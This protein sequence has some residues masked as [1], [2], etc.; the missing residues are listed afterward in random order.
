MSLC[1]DCVIVV[2]HEGTPKGKI[3]KIGG[4]TCYVGT[5]TEECTRDGV[6]LCLTD[7]FGID[8]INTQLL[9]DDF[10]RCGFKTIAIDYLHGDPIPADA[11]KSPGFHDMIKTWIANHGAER[12]RAPIDRVVA[13][14]KDQRVTRFAAVGYCLGGRYA[15]DLAF[16]GVIEVTVVSH[17]SF[18]NIPS[19]LQK[20]KEKSKAPLLIN[21]CE[22]DDQFPELA[23]AHADRI[24]GNGNQCTDTYQR[25]YFAG[26]THGFAVRGDLSKPEVKYGKERAFEVTVEFLRKHF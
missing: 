8:L 12:T 18:L 15:F 10:A 20:Y 22:V 19:D 9:V 21:S 1:K 26:C 5:P 23:Q 3:E 7:A 25:E 6:L 16:D 13:A 17:P 14:L 24:L 4:I 11:L 2:Q